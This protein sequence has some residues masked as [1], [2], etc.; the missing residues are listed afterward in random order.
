MRS[1]LSTCDKPIREGI[2]ELLERLPDEDLYHPKDA[3]LYLLVNQFD[4]EP[5]ADF[6]E[7]WPES[8][9]SLNNIQDISM[10]N[11][12]FL[13]RLE[14]AHDEG[15]IKRPELI[16]IVETA[17][18]LQTLNGRFGIDLVDTTKL[19]RAISLADGYESEFER[20]RSYLFSNDI[21]GSTSETRLAD[22]IIG[23]AEFD[24]LRYEQDIEKLGER[25]ADVLE[26]NEITDPFQAADSMLALQ[27]I[28]QNEDALLKEI[29]EAALRH[30]EEYPLTWDIS[31]GGE[32]SD[33]DS[34]S[35]GDKRTR[36]RLIHGHFAAGKG[37]KVST[38][39]VQWERKIREQRR[40]N[41]L[42][43]FI[44]TYPSTRI[45]SRQTE[46]R[47][48]AHRIIESAESELRIATLRMDLLH[49][50][51]IDRL[52]STDDLEVRIITSTGTSS[53]ERSKMK[54]AVM[55]ELVKRLDG[56]VKEDPLMHARMVIGDDEEA[57]ISSADLTRDQLV[58]EFN[59]GVYSQ[60]NQFVSD[61]I[62]FFDEI[63][64]DADHRE[65]KN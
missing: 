40:Q 55:N 61:A 6:L 35:S 13:F 48:A 14:R 59:A 3:I 42:P 65:V 39:Q 46:I 8:D 11:L 45:Q 4:P 33:W 56:K 44:T 38:T 5:A 49:D 60:N 43:D 25:L 57:I 27:R 15:D 12:P 22:V 21:Y 20:A 36:A 58:D 53:Y 63:W 54:K 62:E 7:S 1:K 2:S 41:D 23:L 50:E 30:S 34:I 26:E 31:F 19:F 64:R 32:E 17:T 24:Y 52:E 51:I 18:N 37:P 29:S 9:Y 47:N 28:P 10:A 16:E